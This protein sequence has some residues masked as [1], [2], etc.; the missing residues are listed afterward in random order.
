[1]DTRLGMVDLTAMLTDWTLTVKNLFLP[2]FCKICG[3]RLLTEENGYFCPTCWELSP[4]V[5]RPFCT[6]CGRPHAGVIGFGSLSNFPCADCRERASRGGL[7]FRRM[8][9]AALYDGA[10]KE[11]IKLFKFY[12]K[13]GLARPLGALMAEFAEREIECDAYDFIVPVPLHKVRERDRGFNQSRLLSQEILSVFPNAR[14]DESLRRLRPTCVQSRLKTA[15]ER[16]ANVVGAF[17]VEGDR[18][19]GSRVLLVDDVV[20]TSGTVS[21]CA[22]ALRRANAGAVDIFAAALKMSTDDVET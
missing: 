17:A 9:G 2:I 16:R 6:L 15:S 21:E 1:M 4:R 7:P 5:E 10:V 19:A 3:C 13:R 20:T 14:I 22:A 11:A 18:L 12:G 8:Y